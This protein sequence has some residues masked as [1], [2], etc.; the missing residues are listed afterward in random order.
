MHFYV[1]DGNIIIVR[2]IR[3]RRKI[4]MNRIAIEMKYREYIKETLV[5]INNSEDA[6]EKDFY[7]QLLAKMT[8]DMRK[9]GFEIEI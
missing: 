4:K 6:E 9:Q 7:L 3:K 2:E 8:T 1:K 5:R